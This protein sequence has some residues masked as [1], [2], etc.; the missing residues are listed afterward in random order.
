MREHEFNSMHM[1]Q[2]VCMTM[3]P[4]SVLLRN[5]RPLVALELPSDNNCLSSDE[6]LQFLNEFVL[7]KYDIVGCEFGLRAI[8][9]PGAGL[10]MKKPW[11]LATNSG[12]IGKSMRRNCTHEA[13]EHTPREGKNILISES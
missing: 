8:F 13:L 11:T 12:N 10:L 6:V 2:C 7:R 5:V 9:E 1:L 4:R 3:K